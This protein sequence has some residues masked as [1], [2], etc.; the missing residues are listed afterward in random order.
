MPCHKNSK[1]HLSVQPGKQ[2][3]LPIISH[4]SGAQPEACH[5]E[6]SPAINSHVESYVFRLSGSG[7]YSSNVIQE[8]LNVCVRAFRDIDWVFEIFHYRYVISDFKAIPAMAKSSQ[9]RA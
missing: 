1:S 8:Y 9:Q 6:W 3:V 7:R 5:Q 4:S 2:L